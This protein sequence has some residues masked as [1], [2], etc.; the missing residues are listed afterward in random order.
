MYS[1]SSML[2]A[3]LVNL[4][5][6]A[7]T[8]IPEP[9]PSALE[10]AAPKDLEARCL[11]SSNLSLIARVLLIKVSPSGPSP[12]QPMD[13][14]ASTGEVNA[15]LSGSYRVLAVSLPRELKCFSPS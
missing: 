15:K 9:A 8:P 2:V 14:S 13:A 11:L 3:L 1:V 7:A 12:S 5:L 6:T 10:I 4:A